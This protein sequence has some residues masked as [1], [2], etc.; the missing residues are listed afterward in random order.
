MESNM[1]R[2]AVLAGIALTVVSVPRICAASVTMSHARGTGVQDSLFAT[3]SKLDT[4]LF[5]T[6]NHCDLPGELQKHASYLAPNLEFYHDKG[7]VSWTRSDYIAKTRMNVCGNFRRYLIPGSM[8]VFPIKDYGAIEQGRH[9]FCEIRSGKC[10]GQ[11]RFF[12]LWHR[13]KD[14]RWEASR[15]FSYDHIPLK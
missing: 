2:L 1:R 15:V 7:G 6:F 5:D 3:V 9:K 14:G 12:I 10:D 13:L 8:Q 11:A 4:G